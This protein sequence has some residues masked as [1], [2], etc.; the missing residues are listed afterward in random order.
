MGRVVIV[1][2]ACGVGKSETLR[3][4]RDALAGRVEEVAVLETDHFY[5]IIDPHWAIAEP[6]ARRYFEMSGW[7][8]RETA[9]HLLRLGFD[10]VAI[11]SNGL[12]EESHVREFVEPFVDAGTAVHHV[13]LDPGVDTIRSRM[14]HRIATLG[15]PLDDVK[16]PEW[17]N[18]QLAWFRGMYGPWTYV[19]DN[20]SLTPAET[21]IAIYE[22][23]ENGKG[24][25]EKL[26]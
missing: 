14:A 21:A 18:G 26:G 20:S 5:M 2:G 11:G 8:L 10:W 1:S 19:L 6:D 15:H 17:I 24:R 25:L 12:N 7:L 22:A 16:S 9:R 23:A 4:M 3:S 13:T